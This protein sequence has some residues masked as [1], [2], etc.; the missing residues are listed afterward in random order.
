[1][2]ESIPSGAEPKKKRQH[3]VP[4]FYLRN[5]SFDGGERLHLVHLETLR[6][7]PRVGLKGQ[8]YEDY[9]YGKDPTVENALQDMEG[10]TAEL[11]RRII[12][13][14]RLPARGTPDDLIFRT[15]VCL[16]WGRTKSHAERS[17]A[18]FSKA[19]KTVYGPAWRAAG[20]TQEQID[21]VEFG[22]E[23]PGLQSLGITADMVPFM[24]DLESKLVVAGNLGEF[25]TSDAP[26]VLTNPYY[27]GRFPGGVAG[28]N[29]RGLAILFPISPRLLAVLYDGDCYRIGA[30]GKRVV[31]LASRSDL[32]ALNNFQC[33]NANDAIY[34]HDET[35]APGHLA[36]F[37]KVI[38][39]RSR[40]CGVVIEAPSAQPA[41]SSSVLHTYQA[42]VSYRPQ[43]S[44]LSLL[45]KRRGE[46]GD[47]TRL[48]ERNP[49]VANLFEEYQR[50][51]NA[52]TSKRGFLD[53][54]TAHS[55]AK[56][57]LPLPSFVRDPQRRTDP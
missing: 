51:V 16:Q 21:D 45:R 43:F 26:V 30:P 2:G 42:D 37:A 34:F 32:I 46:T 7:I 57:G 3:F 25:V 1:M 24:G 18:L 48:E 17:E 36:E 33:L 8:C 4:K 12:A 53:Y 54:F 50:E 35:V 6:S 29:V 41:D 31:P 47:V 10:V 13:D 40:D 55:F 22:T 52:G 19:L 9:F 14:E 20:I 56:A 27:L 11:F 49:E 38:R 28:L 23:K 15:F 44:F 39:L 5:F